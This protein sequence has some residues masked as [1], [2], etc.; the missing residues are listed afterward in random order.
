MKEELPA[1]S[2]GKAHMMTCTGSTSTHTLLRQ[3]EASMM[4]HRAHRVATRLRVY[5]AQKQD[6]A[7][8][9]A[10]RIAVQKLHGP[11]TVRQLAVD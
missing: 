7:A 5:A 9:H 8:P 4:K 2:R 3:A 10:G 6:V 11:R 1:L